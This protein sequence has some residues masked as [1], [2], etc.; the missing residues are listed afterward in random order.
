MKSP[1]MK[2]SDIKY[3]KRSGTASGDNYGVGEAPKVGMMRSSYV[4]GLGKTPKQKI[5]KPPRGMK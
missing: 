2:N 1:K 5:S 3:Q 4:S